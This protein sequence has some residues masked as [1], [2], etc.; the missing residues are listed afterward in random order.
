MWPTERTFTGKNER[1]GAIWHGRKIEKDAS[2]NSEANE[3]AVE[4][5]K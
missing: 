1:S 2:E 3:K 5:T 4:H